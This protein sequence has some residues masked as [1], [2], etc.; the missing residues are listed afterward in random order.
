M[1]KQQRLAKRVEKARKLT[2]SFN[3]YSPKHYGTWGDKS[4][5]NY[6][7]KYYNIE[8]GYK[9]T[10][11]KTPDGKKTIT[12]F[13]I[14]CKKDTGS[15][16]VCEC[17]GNSHNTVCYHGLGAL[18]E[19]F[20]KVDKTISFFETYDAANRMRMSGKVAKVSS[21]Q[22][23]GFLW[24]VIKNKV[25]SEILTSKENINLLRGS[26]EEGID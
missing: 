6:G 4:G 11:I 10:K 17:P 19:S 15:G 21:A 26:E 23:D 1:T 16:V 9:E 18:I 12:E 8:L 24:A 25:A 7:T 5:K 13:I 14:T 22:G 20:L 3:P 2:F